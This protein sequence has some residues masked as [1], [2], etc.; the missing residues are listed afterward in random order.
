MS[1]KNEIEFEKAK[2]LIK[3]ENKYLKQLSSSN[4]INKRH[5]GFLSGLWDEIGRLQFDFLIKECWVE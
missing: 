5:T 4:I 2:A 3:S 1:A